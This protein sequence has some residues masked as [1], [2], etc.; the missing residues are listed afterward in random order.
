M[1]FLV[2]A[3]KKHFPPPLGSDGEQAAGVD[4]LAGGRGGW[5]GWLVD[6]VWG[7]WLGWLV[8][9]LAGWLVGLVGWLG[10]LGWQ[11]ELARGIGF[12]FIFVFKM[13][14]KN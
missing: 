10:C 5:L 3:G 13:Y 1:I 12:D 4:G 11:V 9:G 2:F 6:G 7:G 14:L 8:D